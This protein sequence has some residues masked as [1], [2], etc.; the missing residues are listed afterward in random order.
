MTQSPHACPQ[1]GGAHRFETDSNGVALC[2]CGE[3][4]M[5]VDDELAMVEMTAP[6]FPGDVMRPREQRRAFHER[7]SALL[8]KYGSHS[9]GDTDDVL[10]AQERQWREAG[11]IV[12]EDH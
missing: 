10:D 2:A 8:R 3:I 5:S 7:L 12:P 11:G 4:E 1:S 6:P 9:A